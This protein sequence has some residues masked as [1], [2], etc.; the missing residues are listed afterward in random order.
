MILQNANTFIQKA[1]AQNCLTC[2]TLQVHG[3]LADPVLFQTSSQVSGRR[4]DAAKTGPGNTGRH[5]VA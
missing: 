3:R 5:F 1:R 4:Q 2:K